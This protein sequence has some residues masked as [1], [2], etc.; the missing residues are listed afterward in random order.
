MDA[1]NREMT[2]A[3]ITVLQWWVAAGAPAT[4]TLNELAPPPEVRA[5]LTAR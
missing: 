4:N 3:E 1:S 5:A 2:A